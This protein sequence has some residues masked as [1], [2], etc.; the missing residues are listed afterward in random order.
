MKTKHHA[1]IIH[2]SSTKP[3]PFQFEL[4]FLPLMFNLKVQC[5][6]PDMTTLNT[7]TYQH[8]MFSISNQSIVSNKTNITIKPRD[9][10]RCVCGLNS[11]CCSPRNKSL[12]MSAKWNSHVVPVT[13]DLFLCLQTGLHLLFPSHW[14]SFYVCRLN[15]TCCSP[16]NKSLNMSAIWNSHVVP[17]T[18]DL[19]LCLQTGLHWLFPSHWIS[20]YVCR[21]NSTCCSPRNKSLNMSAKWNSHVVPLTLDLF[22]CLQTKLHMLFP[23][24]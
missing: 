14:I 2:S 16:R 9:L 20:F 21:L 4:S 19:F 10:S 1:F 22:L 23:S 24:Q 17:V 8:R 5:P 18:L 13:L 7:Q 15:S 6:S 12:N 11:K 3:F